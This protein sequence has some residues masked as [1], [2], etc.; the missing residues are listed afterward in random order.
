MVREMYRFLIKTHKLISPRFIGVFGLNRRYVQTI[1]NR[2]KFLACYEGDEASALMFGFLLPSLMTPDVHLDIFVKGETFQEPD[3]YVKMS[4]PV[5]G[6]IK[7]QFQDMIPSRHTGTID[8][9][10]LMEKRNY[11]RRA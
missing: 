1:V 2:T 7:K 11:P 4:D 3:L 9:A 8:R 6:P 10:R 5:F